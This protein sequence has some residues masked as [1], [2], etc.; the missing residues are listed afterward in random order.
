MVAFGI[1]RANACRK[2]IVVPLTPDARSTDGMSDISDV[3]AT[4]PSAAHGVAQKDLAGAAMKLY[5]HEI[6][7]KMKEAGFCVIHILECFSYMELGDDFRSAKDKYGKNWKELTP[8]GDDKTSAEE[9]GKAA[10]LGMKVYKSWTREN[11]KTN[12][13]TEYGFT[14]LQIACLKEIESMIDAFGTDVKSEEHQRL[15]KIMCSFMVA[16]LL[17]LRDQYGYYYPYKYTDTYKAVASVLSA[18]EATLLHTHWEE[19][20]RSL[21]CSHQATIDEM[22][23]TIDGRSVETTATDAARPLSPALSVYST[24]CEWLNRPRKHMNSLSQNL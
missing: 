14:T 8:A 17:H 12:S 20:L 19:T 6:S 9:K 16:A 4:A 3:S 22:M 11:D 23:V 21:T 1:S 5:I 7:S 18:E 2:T 10:P 13:P 24:D 15:R